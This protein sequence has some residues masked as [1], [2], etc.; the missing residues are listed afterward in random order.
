[1]DDI[2]QPDGE[3]V[4]GRLCYLLNRNSEERWKGLEWI[5]NGGGNV[6]GTQTC[7][8]CFIPPEHTRFPLSAHTPQSLEMFFGLTTLKINFARFVV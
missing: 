5:D 1:M 6:R 3:H 7:P 4:D 2:V 8:S